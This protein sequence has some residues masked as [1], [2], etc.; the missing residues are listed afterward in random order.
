MV[1]ILG[2]S[3]PLPSDESLLVKVPFLGKEATFLPGVIH[4]ARSSGAP[5]FVVSPHRSADY[6]HQVVEISPPISMEGELQE[7]LA[8]CAAVMDAAIRAN[9]AQWG[10]WSDIDALASLGL[11]PATAS[12]RSA[13][14]A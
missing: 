5:V 3:A 11:I 2:D 13:V 8:R 7:A 6:R 4:L 10:D 1:T 12:P 14:D 9:P